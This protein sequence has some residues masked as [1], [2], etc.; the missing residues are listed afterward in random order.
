MAIKKGNTL[1]DLKT[2]KHSL[3]LLTKPVKG[4]YLMN[5]H[6]GGNHVSRVWML[7]KP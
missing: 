4:L 5:N 3:T 2:P 6:S 7:H 1:R